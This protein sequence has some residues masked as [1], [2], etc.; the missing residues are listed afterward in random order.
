MAYTKPANAELLAAALAGY[1]YQYEVL[2]ERMAEVRQLL[3]GRGVAPAAAGGESPKRMVSETTRHRMAQAQQRR[4]AGLKKKPY[5]PP[6]KKRKM[7]AEGKARI[8][9]ATRKRW[10]EYRAQKAAR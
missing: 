6:A 2:G 10:A 3:G 5:G 7:S 9:E 1:Q 4:W 8:A